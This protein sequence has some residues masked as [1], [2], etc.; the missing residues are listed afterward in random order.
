MSSALHRSFEDLLFDD[1]PKNDQD[2][3]EALQQ[4]LAETDKRINQLF[5]KTS[6]GGCWALSLVR[7][8]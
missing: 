3:D 1:V 5:P 6:A 8:S 2:Q 7:P 4:L